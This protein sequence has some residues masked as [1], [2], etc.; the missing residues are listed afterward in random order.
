[1]TLFQHLS[2]ELKGICKASV[3]N[4]RMTLEMSASVDF[5]NE[6]VDL[7]KRLKYDNLPK[8]QDDFKQ[9]LQGKIIRHIA[10]FS[11]YLDHP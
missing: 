11:G 9:E 5:L 3:M 6:Y 2:L 4:T 10:M 8:Y 7:L 1:M